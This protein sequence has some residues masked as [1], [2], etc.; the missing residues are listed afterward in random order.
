AQAAL[1]VTASAEHRPAVAVS[2]LRRALIG[3]ERLRDDLPWLPPYLTANLVD[4]LFLAGRMSEATATAAQLRAHAGHR[5]VA[6]S[7]GAPVD[8][9]FQRITSR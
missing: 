9:E 6:V 2:A 5:A 1:A 3:A 4:G 8:A 7:L